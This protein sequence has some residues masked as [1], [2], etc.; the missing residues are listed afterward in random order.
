MVH[1][2]HYPRTVWKNRYAGHRVTVKTYN[3]KNNP[4]ST[5]YKPP[6]PLPPP[7]S[8]VW[9]AQQIFRPPDI[10]KVPDAPLGWYS[11]LTEW[12]LGFVRLRPDR[13]V[14]YL[15]NYSRRRSGRPAVSSVGIYCALCALRTAHSVIITRAAQL[16][17]S[18]L[19]W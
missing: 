7:F 19:L 5:T 4:S 6:P 9:V 17:W 12:R 14:S 2:V 10:T 16:T 18:Y 3:Y 15:A 11:S 1:V 8:S 13:S